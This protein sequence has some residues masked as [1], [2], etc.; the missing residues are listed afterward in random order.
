MADSGLVRTAGSYVL[1][2]FGAS[3]FEEGEGVGVV[4]SMNDFMARTD[5]RLADAQVKSGLITIAYNRAKNLDPNG[6]ISD[7][8]FKAALE[9][10]TA[11]FFATNNITREFLM[12]FRNDALAAQTIN[13]NI[14]EIFT[15]VDANS[16]NVVLKKNIRAIKAI[17]IFKK[18]RQMTSSINMVRRYKQRYESNNDSLPRDLYVLDLARNHNP[19]NTE[20][21]VYEVK[22]IT[23]RS[24][25]ATDLPI[26]TDNLGKMLTAKELQERGFRL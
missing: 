20:D 11:S 15:N 16:E 3:A 18:V 25:V 17:P 14:L 24:V 1:E 12:G 26:Y 22:N 13:D 21:Q 6:R 10:I 7:R 8:D 4:K 9:S 19:A 2:K 5:G 23:G